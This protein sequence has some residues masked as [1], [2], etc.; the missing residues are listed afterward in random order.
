MSVGSGLAARSAGLN[1]RY[2]LGGAPKKPP[3]KAPPRKPPTRPPAGG[4]PPSSEPF[5]D[6]VTA[7]STQAKQQIQDEI[8]ALTGQQATQLAS[9]RENARQLGLASQAGASLIHGFGTPVADAYNEAAKTL[10]ALGVG[11]TGQLRSDAAT[12]A[13]Q[14]AHDIAVGAQPQGANS[15]PGPGTIAPPPV[16]NHAEELA[17]YLYGSRAAQPASALGSAAGAAAAREAAIPETIIGHGQDLGV[18]TLGAAQKA[19]AAISPQIAAV[20]AR[21]PQLQ[22]QILASLSTAQAKLG[23]ANTPKILGSSSSGYYAFDPATGKM[24]QIL[25]P[26]PGSTRVQTFSSGGNEYAINPDGTVQQITH[27]Q[28][29]GPSLKAVRTKNGTAL[30][31]TRT[32]RTVRTIPGT[33]PSTSSA[34]APTPNELNQMVQ[35]FKTGG[36]VRQTVA[37]PN[38]DKNGN[39]IYK[40]V[41]K[42]T[43]ALKFQQA[44]NRLRALHVSDI[45]AR[46]LLAT[47][48]KRGEQGRG[49]LTNEEQTVLRSQRG[50]VP[51]A[52][53]YK[54]VGFL[55]RN[56][57]AALQRLGLHP[58][59]HW[60]DGGHTSTQDFGTVYVIDQTY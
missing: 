53:V 11:Y 38:P 6:L 12:E 25:G 37:L 56:Q 29:S 27:N 45:D 59:G 60:V 31:D 17:N 41:T 23:R 15:V 10:A 40:T 19:I 54:G 30:V 24:T 2:G 18:G 52:H 51:R 42:R 39:P 9:A 35:T 50:L 43:G 14:V 36:I 49:W 57:Y 4:A 32:G 21:F 33:V 1:A 48:Y 47:V 26:A 3:A 44:Y 34:K 46:H 22:S 55:D 28:P 5:G 16:V 13:A 8:A 7:A 20:A 58:P